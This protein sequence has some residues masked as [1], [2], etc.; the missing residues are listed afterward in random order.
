MDAALRQFVR[1]RA[2][3]DCEYCSLP[4]EKEPLTFHI[5]HIVPRQH[6]GDDS[7]ENLALACQHCNLRKGTNLSGL[8]P[9]TGA[10]TRLFHPRQDVWAEHFTESE[11]EI[12]GRTA[13]G[14]ATT[15]LL[16]MNEDGR[17][18]LRAG[19]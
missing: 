5:E 16:K 10:A 12:T 11:G 6:G 15:R 2:D 3:N 7:P 13:I 9:E 1:R 8:D 4:Q 19:T 14:R 18:E 17:L